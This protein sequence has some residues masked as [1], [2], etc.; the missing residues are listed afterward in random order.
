MRVR[1]K[2]RTW[3]VRLTVKGRKTQWTLGRFPIMSP[4]AAREAAVVKTGDVLKRPIAAGQVVKSRTVADLV[5]HWL[6][7]HRT[8]RKGKTPKDVQAL[9]RHG[10]IITDAWGEAKCDEITDADALTLVRSKAAGTYSQNRLKQTIRALWNLGVRWRFMNADT[11]N[12]AVEVAHNRERR[13]TVRAL[14]AEEIAALIGAAQQ[15]P[16]PSPSAALCMLAVTGCRMSE[17][18]TLHRDDFDADEGTITLRDRKGGDDLVLPLGPATTTFMRDYLATH[19]SPWC[20]PSSRTGEPL[21]D[22]RKCWLWSRKTAKLPKGTRLH[23]LRAAV[24]TLVSQAAGIA[25]AQRVLGH[26]NVATTSR[27]TRP[28]Q[29]EQRAGLVSLEHAIGRAAPKQPSAF[30]AEIRAAAARGDAAAI[31]LVAAL[32]RGRA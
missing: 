16:S 15:Y 18:L 21:K 26:E 5:G 10:K 8:R 27:Y 4:K 30:E 11:P 20:F 23:D 29:A 6:E 31:E 2:S 3:I 17:I 13:R 19:K 28:G 24:A 1:A 9:K 22:V 14:R 12:P 32:E 25:V 7:H